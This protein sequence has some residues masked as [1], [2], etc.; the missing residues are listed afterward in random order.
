VTFWQALILGI[1]E[2]L[3]E[4]LPVSSTAH[5]VVAQRILRS[6][7]PGE[8]FGV[9]IQ[10]GAILA[11]CVYYNARIYRLLTQAT[12][13]AASR[14]FILNVIIGTLPAAVI[15]LAVNKWLEQHVFA[16]SALLW[17]VANT[18][19]LG[20]L[21]ILVLERRHPA[22]PVTDAM[23]IPPRTALL[24]GFW[25]LLAAV[26]P[27][28]SRSAAT[29]LGG[30]LVGVDRRAATEFSFFL[31][32][33]AMAG[34]SL[35]KLA[36]HHDELHGRLGPIAIGFVVSFVVAL[37]VV[38][39]LLRYVARHDFRAFG[40]YRIAAGLLLAS[41]LALHWLPP[42]VDDAPAAHDAAK[43]SPFDRRH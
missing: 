12:R 21:G 31:A 9:V 19:A 28:T 27:G 8:V 26:L 32:I 3:T 43:A 40:W 33:P 38:H 13:D 39:W 7:D 41:A 18:L 35:L 14:R 15:G 4:F 24:I 30:M 42:P 25:P 10:L 6:S 20:G 37:G 2:G 29:I 17:I 34:A 1:V 16:G 36:K 23:A 22:T 5:I 11:V